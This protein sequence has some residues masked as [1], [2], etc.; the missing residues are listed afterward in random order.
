MRCLSGWL[1][2]MVACGNGDS[3]QT[4]QDQLDLAAEEGTVAAVVDGRSVSVAEVQAVVDET[5][6]SPRAALDRLVEREL[7]YGEANERGLGLS[8]PVRRVREQAMVQAFLEREVEAAILPSSIEHDA[9]MALYRSEDRYSR[10]QRR[11]STHILFVYEGDDA[12]LSARSRS[13]AERALRELQQAERP[14]EV[15]ERYRGLDELDALPIRVEDLEPA[16]PGEL[17]Q[18]SFLEGL[19]SGPGRGAAAHVVESSFGWHAILVTEVVESY[20]APWDEVELELRKRVATRRR[21][22]LLDELTLDLSQRHRVIV[23]EESIGAALAVDVGEQAI[24]AP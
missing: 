10:P 12:G 11:R 9:L 24:G 7:L 18:E 19:F 2:L 8:R 23:V 6:L 1:F 20:E 17:Y 14:E 21:A 22:V 15:I 13:L 4:E 5:G 16:G 3:S